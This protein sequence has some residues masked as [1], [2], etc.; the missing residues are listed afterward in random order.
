MHLI[1]LKPVTLIETNI[2]F[3]RSANEQKAT[4]NSKIATVSKNVEK[5]FNRIGIWNQ[6]IE[7]W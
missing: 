3:Y 4:K 1:K 7:L 5:Y 2:K 6:L